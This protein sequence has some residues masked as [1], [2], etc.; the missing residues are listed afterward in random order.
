MS[1]DRTERLLN[2]VLCLLD[3]PHPVDRATI[4]RVV[5]GYEDSASDQA[6]ER[7]FERD[8]DEL[9]GMGIPIETVM[10]VSNEVAGYRID[11]RQYDLA[12]VEVTPSELAV[13]GLAARVWDAAA[14]GA[15]ARTAWLKLGGTQ[16]DE[17][18]V[19][20]DGPV[21]LGASSFDRLVPDLWDAVR[22]GTALAFDYRKP[23]ENSPQ[24]REVEPWGVI[25]YAGAW[26]LVGRDRQR[27]GVRVFRTS[28]I[29]GSVT[30]LEGRFSRP[31]VDLREIVA[32]W[33][34]R[35]GAPAEATATVRVTGP[36]SL[37]QRWRATRIIDGVAQVPYADHTALVAHLVSLGP[38][39][40][41]LEPQQARA[42]VVAAL[43]RVVARH[44]DLA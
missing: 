17:A 24:R 18:E 19:T 29:V 16:A 31:D 44:R 35:V 26:Y 14:L 13:L 42:D 12:P 9:R 40:E 4:R 7:M 38:D 32:T 36:A 37:I 3:S 6:F 30:P 25:S 27:D 8:K 28:R 21:E 23:D 41:V 33:G 43:E 11:R 34:P 2:L 15:G 22:T 20:S 5:P 1:V 10:T 39:V